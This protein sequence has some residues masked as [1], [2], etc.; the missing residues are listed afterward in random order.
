[1]ENSEEK[2]DGGTQRIDGD[3]T[4]VESKHSERVED[5][6]SEVFHLL[7]EVPSSSVATHPQVPN[8]KRMSGGLKASVSLVGTL[9]RSWR[10]TSSESERALS[11]SQE[12]IT[13][14][15]DRHDHVVQAIT[16][17][18]DRL[19]SYSNTLHESLGG[20][21]VSTDGATKAAGNAERFL[22]QF[23]GEV[24]VESNAV[25]ETLAQVGEGLQHVLQEV[26]HKDSDIAAILTKLDMTSVN[27]GR[28]LEELIQEISKAVR[29]YDA[30]KHELTV[31]HGEQAPLEQK[32]KAKF[33][34]IDGL[35]AKYLKL[36]VEDALRVPNV[37]LRAQTLSSLK[38]QLEE[39]AT[40]K[41]DNNPQATSRWSGWF[42]TNK[43]KKAF[44]SVERFAKNPALSPRTTKA[45][46]DVNAELL[47]TMISATYAL[48]YFDKVHTVPAAST[49][50][51]AGVNASVR[52]SVSTPTRNSA[53][54]LPLASVSTPT[55]QQR[56][57]DT[58]M[59]NKAVLLHVRGE[60]QK[61]QA[62]T[63]GLIGS[64][65]PT[66]QFWGKV[67]LAL[68]LAIAATVAAI[69]LM[70]ALGF[71]LPTF[72]VPYVAYLQAS[73]LVSNVLTFVSTQLSIT[74]AASASATALL[75]AGIF[76][77]VGY[78]LNRAGAPSSLKKDLD[79]AAKDLD[80]AI[81]DTPAFRAIRVA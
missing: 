81:A 5:S 43:E 34:E 10:K 52:S 15:D 65:S 11:G 69:A 72:L 20:Y 38:E 53:M 56:L 13:L 30:I 9:E 58:D 33:A 41:Q 50:G 60:L 1:M 62:R 77:G 17:R 44:D 46:F 25:R 19:E 35:A 23:R 27:L 14:L 55:S 8:A 47:R 66:M 16:E 7:N 57:E 36:K 2:I 79:H 64:Q 49:S 70:S 31:E 26:N 6:D 12:Q 80:D 3:I 75:T 32:A 54:T 61:L 28:Q 45:N 21:K 78:G 48:T 22:N 71:A 24:Q 63:D 37:S 73:A 29:E 74:V 59:V 42:S 39:I 67:L 40:R 18:L 76:G 51:S 4:V 68:A